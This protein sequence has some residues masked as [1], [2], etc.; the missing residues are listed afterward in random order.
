M[1]NEAQVICEVGL[2]M[3]KG[4][5]RELNLGKGRGCVGRN[6]GRVR[7]ELDMGRKGIKGEDIG[8]IKGGMGTR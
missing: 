3:L 7:G 1:G 4:K 2:G 8:S 6:K 5:G